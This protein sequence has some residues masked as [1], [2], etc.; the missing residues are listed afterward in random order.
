[1]HYNPREAASRSR[2]RNLNSSMNNKDSPIKESPYKQ[3]SSKVNSRRTIN[4]TR[5]PIQF[6]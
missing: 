1:M 2:E 5:N 3:V 4:E 6:T